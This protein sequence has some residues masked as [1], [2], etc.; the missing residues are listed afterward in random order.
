MTT[1]LWRVAGLALVLALAANVLLW[2]ITHGRDTF[3]IIIA[4]ADATAAIA[5]IATHYVKPIADWTGESLILAMAAWLANAIE[6]AF[7]DRV[8]WESRARSC[9]VYLAFAIVALGMFL[10]LHLA[11]EAAAETERAP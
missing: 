9:L 6:F 7:E 2:P 1:R 8:S 3:V 10:V 4:I 11:E 5:L